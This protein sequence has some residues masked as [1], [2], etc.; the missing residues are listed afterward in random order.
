MESW[1]THLEKCNLIFYH[2]KHHNRAT[3][4][5]GKRPILMKN[6]DRLRLIPFSTKRAKFSE[7]KRV[8]GQL[9]EILVHGK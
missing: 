7:V 9:S 1:K 8:F 5:G 6:D 3:L 2:A 4:F